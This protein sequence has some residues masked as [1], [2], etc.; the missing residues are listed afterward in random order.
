MRLGVGEGWA[1]RGVPASCITNEWLEESDVISGPVAPKCSPMS[2][3]QLQ[4]VEA[5]GPSVSGR[6]AGE[7]QDNTLHD[8]SDVGG[9]MVESKP[10]PSVSWASWLLSFLLNH[11][12]LR[13]LA[14]RP[15]L[16]RALTSY[17]RSPRAPHRLRVVPL[18]TL[19]I[20]S[21]AEFEHGPPPLEE[22]DG[23]MVAVL[24]ECDR[25][26]R[27]RGPGSMV[28]RTSDCPG[29]L[30][31]E[32]KWANE[33]LLLLTDLAI[34]TRRAQ[35]SL[36]QPLRELSLISGGSQEE[37]VPRTVD[38]EQVRTVR[39]GADAIGI[40]TVKV[41]LPPFGTRVD[42]SPVEEGED[43][44]ADE[45]ERSLADRLLSSGRLL[46]AEDRALLEM[47]QR[48]A[49]LPDV[50]AST[51]LSSTELE[52]DGREEQEKATIH[53]PSR[54]LHHLIEI[55][56]T[57][58]VLRSGWPSPGVMSAPGIP[59]EGEKRS[60]VTSEPAPYLDAI[61]C[62]AWMDAVGPAAVIETEHPFREGTQEDTLCF[63][64]AEEVV[65]F[66]DPRSSMQVVS[67]AH[68]SRSALEFA[69]VFIRARNWIIVRFS[70]FF[71]ER[72]HFSVVRWSFFTNVSFD[73]RVH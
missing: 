51:P 37:K 10:T 9:A 73:A 3:A 67:E 63:H 47:D 72:S 44:E 68:R 43:E 26:T 31:L 16:F 2:P 58:R 28:W 1:L 57:L 33:G 13:R 64:G 60:L 32:T 4:S 38:E 59:V 66:L 50:A 23:L 65:V 35:N 55:M 41:S 48:N 34:A 5:P 53:S 14:M 40:G 42:E 56:D 22:L 46:C 27:G 12:S 71:R 6:Q 62:E 52:G 24:Q 61:L 15:S 54:C 30:Q 70:S 29:G 21:H 49:V 45:V 8:Q 20:R 7:P 11:P 17:L 19:L 69:D 36:R 18:L 25:A 39:P